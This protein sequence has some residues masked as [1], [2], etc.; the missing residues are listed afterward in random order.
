MIDANFDIECRFFR[1]GSR[2]AFN[3][4]ALLRASWVL[5]ESGGIG[6]IEIVAANGFDDLGFEPM[7]GDVVEVWAVGTGETAPRAR[8]KVTVPGRQL[9]LR[10]ERRI[11]AYG[12]MQDMASVL[13][14]KVVVR[15]LGADL[16]EYAA[17]VASDYANRRGL[18][19]G[20]DFLTDIQPCGITLTEFSAPDTL[21]SSAMQSLVDQASGSV[22][23]GWEVDPASALDR[24]YFRPRVAEVGNQF[25]VGGSVKAINATEESQALKNCVKIVGGAPK[26][27]NSGEEFQLRGPDSAGWGFRESAVRG[28]VRGGVGRGAGMDLPVRS[29]PQLGG[30]WTTAG[31]IRARRIRGSITSSSTMTPRTTAA[32]PAE[33]IW[34]EVP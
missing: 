24:F 20:A 13:M 8:G 5:Q 27:P 1:S 29:E 31:R 26:Y 21:A 18:A 34:Q 22:V 3:P 28:R 25:F 32:S 19:L 30:L 9:E 2:L 15:Y 12:R 10:E 16:A 33:E 11:T 6:Q 4:A 14:D 7:V 23:W 17:V